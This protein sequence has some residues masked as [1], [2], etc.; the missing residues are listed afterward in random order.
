MSVPKSL[1]SYFYERKCYLCEKH[2]VYP[3]HDDAKK[4]TH[5]VRFSE[6]SKMLRSASPQYP[7]RASDARVIRL[8]ADQ[9]AVLQEQFNRW[10]RAPHAADIV[11]LAAETGLSESDV[12]A[13]YAI[14]LAQWRKEQGLGGNLGLH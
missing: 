1:Q 5:R 10:P 12:E 14:R 11:L 8:T 2:T 9:E 3:D 13:W 4:S 7:S 6:P